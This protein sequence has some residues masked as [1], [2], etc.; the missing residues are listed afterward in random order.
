[1]KKILIAVTLSAISFSS[2]AWEKTK[3]YHPTSERSVVEMA[4]GKNLKALQV[5]NYEGVSAISFVNVMSSCKEGATIIKVDGAYYKGINIPGNV[6]ALP[7][8]YKVIFGESAEYLIEGMM[9]SS[10]P[11]IVEGEEFSTIGFSSQYKA[12]VK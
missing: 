7:I 10:K 5:G 11:M 12:F 2:L 6:S 3:D 4:K 8:C 1:M 9:T